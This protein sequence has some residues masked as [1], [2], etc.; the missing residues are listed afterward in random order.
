MYNIKLCISNNIKIYFRFELSSKFDSDNE[1]KRFV[2]QTGQ[3]GMLKLFL[4]QFSMQL[5]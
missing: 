2:L 4:I 5:V 3:N 1:G